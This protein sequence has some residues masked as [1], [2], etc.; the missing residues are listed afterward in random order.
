MAACSVGL[1]VVVDFKVVV[2]CATLFG[3]SYGTF[4]SVD[5]AM[6]CAKNQVML[7][8]GVG[9]FAVERANPCIQSVAWYVAMDGGWLTLVCTHQVID[10][11]PAAHSNA[12]DLAVWHA[13]IALP[14]V[15]H[16]GVPG[17][18]RNVVQV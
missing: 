2:V 8:N 15:C 18:K 1:A 11:L 14:N 10:V 4:L 13:A 5:F 6:V 12:K 16:S 9:T 7:P 3:L 17:S